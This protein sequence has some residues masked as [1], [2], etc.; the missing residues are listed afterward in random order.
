MAAASRMVVANNSRIIDSSTC[1]ALG[2]CFHI[3]GACQLTF[4]NNSSIINSTAPGGS[5]MRVS[6]ASSMAYGLRVIGNQQV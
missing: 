1:C 5:A 6:G 4:A 3:V 2:G